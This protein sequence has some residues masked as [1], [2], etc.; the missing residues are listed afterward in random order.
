MLEG[1]V[2]GIQR[3]LGCFDLDPPVVPIIL[4]AVQ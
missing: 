3:F 2:P 4:L 1:I